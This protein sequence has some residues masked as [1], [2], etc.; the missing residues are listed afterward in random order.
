MIIDIIL[1]RG[2]TIDD[3]KDCWADAVIV[4]TPDTNIIYTG[5]DEWFLKE[6]L[7]QKRW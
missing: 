5:F 1:K 4:K 6:K 7:L 2:I 3:I